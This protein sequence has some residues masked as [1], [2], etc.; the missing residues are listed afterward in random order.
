MSTII[1]VS[2]KNLCERVRKKLQKT[3]NLNIFIIVG[4]KIGGRGSLAKN[5]LIKR[6]NKANKNEKII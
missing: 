2:K 4:K 1:S 5:A 3:K 6:R